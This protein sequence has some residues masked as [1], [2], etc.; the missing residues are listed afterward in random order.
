MA[1]CKLKLRYNDG[2][3]TV[4]SSLNFSSPDPHPRLS[5]WTRKNFLWV[6]LLTF[7]LF[8]PKTK[9]RLTVGILTIIDNFWTSLRFSRKLP[10]WFA[11]NFT[12]W[13]SGCNVLVLMSTR[14]L[15]LPRLPSSPYPHARYVSAE[16]R[17]T[18]EYEKWVSIAL[19]GVV[20]SSESNWR[21]FVSK[22]FLC[23]NLLYQSYMP[24]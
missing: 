24:L 7:S 12:H 8:F 14:N 5:S 23:L 4:R 22:K 10:V 20:D 16:P 17:L 19:R 18:L 9:T 15:G 2:K 13:F 1:S 21:E 11:R 6:L 3:P